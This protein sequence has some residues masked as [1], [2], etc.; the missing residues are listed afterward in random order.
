[1]MLPSCAKVFKKY[2]LDQKNLLSEE[3][4]DHCE[5]YLGTWFDF[6]ASVVIMELSEGRRSKR[7][8]IPERY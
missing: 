6:Y 3:Q 7:L 2:I 1:M 8:R 4:M 5:K